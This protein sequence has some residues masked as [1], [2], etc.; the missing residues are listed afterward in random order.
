[1]RAK[2]FIL[3]DY[4]PIKNRE[5]DLESTLEVQ[6]ALNLAKMAIRDDAKDSGYIQQR[7]Q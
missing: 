2:K 7:N 6:T 4:L 5:A 1:M 3:Y